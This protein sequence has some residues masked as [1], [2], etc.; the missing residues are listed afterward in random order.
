MLPISADMAIDAWLPILV[1]FLNF[2]Y[3]IEI[4]FLL[5]H[6]P[7]EK[8]YSCQL[9]WK[10]SWPFEN[11][12]FFFGVWLIGVVIIFSVS[13]ADSQQ[14][15]CDNPPADITNSKKEGD[16]CFFRVPASKTGK[17]Y[18]VPLG[19][20]FP[21]Y[22][23]DEAV[24]ICSEYTGATL[25]MITKSMTTEE[26]SAY[27]N[28]AAEFPKE[29]FHPWLHHK[30]NVLLGFYLIAPLCSILYS[31]SSIKSGFQFNPRAKIF[32][33]FSSFQFLVSS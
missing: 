26:R 12:L 2:N 10:P 18:T 9:L 3:F 32:H 14:L 1:G 21:R 17:V 4:F 28:L 30:G 5:R 11:W 6:Q 8:F 19:A 33:L 31:Q 13:R 23:K 22:D 25:P 24:N 27:Y 15:I 29:S 16:H 20:K 7:K